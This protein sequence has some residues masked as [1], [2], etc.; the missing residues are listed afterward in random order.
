MGLNS[1][2]LQLA[3]GE[4]QGR[5]DVS[6]QQL[7]DAAGGHPAEW[8]SKCHAT[9]LLTHHSRSWFS[10][11]AQKTFTK[12]IASNFEIHL[13]G[14]MHESELGGQR[15]LG[16]S[17]GYRWLQGRSL[18]GLERW[19]ETEQRSHGYSVGR[20]AFQEDKVDFQIWPRMLVDTA[21]GMIPDHSAGHAPS[22]FISESWPRKLRKTSVAV[23]AD[24]GAQPGLLAENDPFDHHWYV[25]RP[26]LESEVFHTL[27]RVGTPAWLKGPAYMG[28]TWLCKYVC[29]WIRNSVS[30]RFQ[31]A[32]V[33]IG[34]LAGRAA[35][36]TLDSFLL[37]LCLQIGDALGI[38]E[39][40]VADRWRR[41]PGGPKER[42][43]ILFE[44]LL[45]PSSQTA[46]VVAIDG[47]K[48]IS[49]QLSNELFGL[50]RRWCDFGARQPWRRLRL[51]LVYPRIPDLGADQSP[52]TIAQEI[53]VEGFSSR[54]M[55]EMFSHYGLKDL[56]LARLHQSLD[57]DPRWLRMA[58][59]KLWHKLKAL[60]GSNPSVKIQAP[61]VD[62]SEVIDDIL[63]T[64]VNRYRQKLA[65]TPAWRDVLLKIRAGEPLTR[66]PRATL[67][68]MYDY[69]LI[70][71]RGLELEYGLRMRPI[72]N[73]V[74]GD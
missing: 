23:S 64:I 32:E 57:G 25:R 51:M 61:E 47:F 9:L 50:L 14:H 59:W 69:G 27:G 52:F 39:S 8:K 68:A 33:Q 72:M 65:R 13:Y 26:D 55:A 37:A 6:L 62:L 16:S 11:R 21:Q 1:A 22:G 19:G 10:D 31:V 46:V 40:K 20:L 58:A 7:R 56:D 54:Q 74:V 12:E 24:D 63:A 30:R 28:K 4:Y 3:D 53:T 17:H 15:L 67:D 34:A 70:E 38:D 48:S 5:L 44:Q 49:T 18:F 2:F 66:V 60:E 73:A 36:D 41:A 35:I 43:Q 42:A 71:P 45:L 29:H